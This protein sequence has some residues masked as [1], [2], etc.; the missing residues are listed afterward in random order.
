MRWLPSNSAPRSVG[1]ADRQHLQARHVRF[2]HQ[3]FDVDLRIAQG[4][5]ETRQPLAP[6]TC[7]VC[8]IGDVGVDQ[9]DRRVLFQRRSCARG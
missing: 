3:R 7:V 9:Q 8:G 1:A 4:V 6:S 2:E 5:D